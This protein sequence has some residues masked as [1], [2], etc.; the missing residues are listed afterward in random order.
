MAYVVPQVLVHQ[1]FQTLPNDVT[2]WLRAFIFGPHYNLHRY[3][4]ASEKANISLGDLVYSADTAYSWPGREAGE[5]VD[6]DYTKLFLD[7]AYLRYIQETSAAGINMSS[8]YYN[9]IRWTSKNIVGKTGYPLD[10]SFYGR[11]VQIGD[12]VKITKGAYTLWTY[13]TGFAAD[14]VASQINQGVDLDADPDSNNF[15][16]ATAAGTVTPDVGN[17]FDGSVTV[18]AADWKGYIKRL[19]TETYTLTCT[20]ASTG[21]DLTTATFSLTSAS[22]EDDV[23]SY[24]PTAAFG[25]PNTIG[26]LNLKV[27][28][29][30]SGTETDVSLGDTF[31]IDMTC[32]F[33]VP[34]GTVG[35]TAS[36]YTG[37]YETTYIVTC[38]KGG[39]AATSTKPE[40]TVTTTT[41][42]DISGP[43]EW[44]GTGGS[45]FSV[46]SYG[47][48]LDFDA[49]AIALGDIWYFD[50]T[51]AGEGAIKTA[52]LA[53][54]LDTGS[55]SPSDDLD[56]DLF[57]RKNVELG[58][59]RLGH[60]PLKNF[61]QTST[62]ITVKANPVITD[63]GWRNGTVEL[64]I[65]KGDQYVEYR[66]LL[67][68]YTTGVGTISD[69]SEVETVLGPIS[70][71]NPLAYGVYNALLN[72]DSVEVKYAAVATDDLSGYSA[73]IDM[74]SDREDVYSLVPLTTD[75]T[76]LSMVEA[77]VDSSSTPEIG[78]W[79]IAW[80]STDLVTQQGVL[81]ED[82]SEDPILATITDDPSST[83]T[84]YTYVTL[85][86]GDLIAAGVQ[87]GDKM[88]Y[89][90]TTDGFG[91]YSYTT[92]VVDQV[93]SQTTCL[94]VEG[95][96]SEQAVPIKAEFWHDM[97]KDEQASYIA[98]KAGAIA[99]RRVRLVH[100]PGAQL[101]GVSIPDKYVGCMLAGLRSSAQPHQGLTN[102]EFNGLDYIDMAYF[103]T[104][105]LNTMAGNGV[106]LIAQEPLTSAGQAGRIYTRHQLTT[107]N[108][109]LNRQEDSV[110]T[111]VD[112]CSFIFRDEFRP[113]IGR[114]N[115]TDG[116][117]ARVRHLCG[118]ILG[119]IQTIGADTELGPMLNGGEVTDIR[120]HTV[121]EDRLVVEIS[122]DVPYPLNGLEIYLVV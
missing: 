39:D 95:P 73:V 114:V 67:S 69:I 58:A 103:S 104:S 28:I 80:V 112:T 101:G 121:L 7:D 6:Q 106:W 35:P 46:G 24:T 54:N 64:P 87:P 94:L 109:D 113:Y 3:S 116:L 71:D 9:R 20:Q 63:S 52:I 53:N 97:S 61:E 34:A 86:N 78:R 40:F 31:E 115:I 79:R 14:A 75:A 81:T 59:D 32:G 51:P 72:S 23:A 13:V 66:G 21:G 10:S 16:A 100:A 4:V 108:T 5:V 45:A 99:N 68:T 49:N 27:T 96:S 55:V 111:N 43:T 77:H 76:V 120:Q 88:R 1:E 102:V 85:S 26:D 117:L 11:D 56:V 15:G 38:T 47:L 84:Q 60:A 89:A 90:Y 92:Y 25:S 50:V 83:G 33:T 30:A 17:T 8:T 2:V 91:N 29:T 22:G 44:T 65:I 19:A 119:Y 74:I 18:S 98:G 62:Q 70:Q 42:V 107:D 118:V 93:L 57:I 110:T 36:S 12:G 41:G 37:P 105:Q 82:S 122:L 48:T